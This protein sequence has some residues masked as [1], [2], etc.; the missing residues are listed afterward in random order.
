MAKKVTI[1]D[2]ALTA[3]VSIGTVDRVL[4]KR[5][6]Y[7]A[8]TEKR[9]NEAIRKLEYHPS[10]IASALVTMR[11]RLKIGITYPL[12]QQTP[13]LFWENVRLGVAR[14]R[15]ELIPFGIEL[16]EDCPNCFNTEAQQQSLIRLV[17]QNVN[18]IVTTAFNTKIS[19]RFS[20][21]I[22]ASI[23]FATAI[24]R[25]WG[26]D[27]LFHIGPDDQAMGALIAKLISL[28]C[29]PQAKI[30]IIAPNMDVEG[31]QKRLNGFINKISTELNELKILQISPIIARTITEAYDAVYLETLRVIDQ[32]PGLDAIYV[33][34]GFVKT[35]ANAV[36]E[37][38][39]SVKVFG[40]EYF[41]GEDS[42]LNDGTICATI[43]QNSGEQWYQAIM[44]MVNYLT[45]KSTPSKTMYA[46][47]DVIL[48][49]TL[50]FMNELLP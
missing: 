45:G 35:C 47:C 28:Y 6:R 42:Y 21:Y 44:E 38:S 16:I 43:Y 2:V 36:K 50:P 40:H 33:T 48:K 4:H 24:N 27:Y 8:E 5:G 41:I 9:V 11:K 7:S 13:E 34:N 20:Q 30:V 23:P 14:A 1:K 25:S 32:Y 18:G 12:D 17:D 22:P 19:E 10:E 26:E 15:Q 49:E 29:T 39:V 37:S 3:G 46:K 31:T